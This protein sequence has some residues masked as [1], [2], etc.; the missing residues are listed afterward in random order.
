MNV[1]TAVQ[2][3]PDGPLSSVTLKPHTLKTT[4]TWV[5]QLPCYPSDENSVVYKK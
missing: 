5:V 2:L 4:P 3:T 1:T